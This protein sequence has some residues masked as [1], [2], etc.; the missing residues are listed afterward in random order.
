MTNATHHLETFDDF[1]GDSNGIQSEDSCY[2]S[3]DLSRSSSNANAVVRPLLS[4]QDRSGSLSSTS[5]E[6]NLPEQIKIELSP[7]RYLS[8][9][10]SSQNQLKKTFQSLTRRPLNNVHSSTYLTYDSIDTP[11]LAFNSTLSR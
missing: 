11:P 4:P 5:V 6:E 1:K 7:S 10:Q 8:T 2:G 3:N 9:F